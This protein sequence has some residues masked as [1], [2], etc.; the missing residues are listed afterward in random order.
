[1]FNS[2][3]RPSPTAQ[4][5]VG[6]QVWASSRSAHVHRQ[7]G[8]LRRRKFVTTQLK[9]T[10]RSIPSK[11]SLSTFNCDCAMRRVQSIDDIAKYSI[12]TRQSSGKWCPPGVNHFKKKRTIWNT[13]NGNGE[14]FS[15]GTSRCFRHRLALP[16]KPLKSV[17]DCSRA[18]A[19]HTLEIIHGPASDSVSQHAAPSKSRLCKREPVKLAQPNN[20]T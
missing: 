19:A 11:P 15:N 4:S 12:E 2:C 10:H 18:S 1:M 17:A 6:V 14:L 5:Q 8:S 13:V 16:P 20:V 3:K 7:E 9:N